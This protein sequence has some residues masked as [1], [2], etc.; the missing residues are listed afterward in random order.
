MFQIDPNP[1]FTETVKVFAPGGKEELG[2]FSVTYKALTIPEM[3]G[4][5]F[6]TPAGATALL[7]EVV[8]DFDDVLDAR[9]K[10]LTYAGGGLAT[11]ISLNHVRQPMLGAY[12]KAL[13]GASEGN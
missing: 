4:F 11:L 7:E 3:E 13:A 2:S 6:R 1:I 10:A 12:L 9:G 5:D 8:L